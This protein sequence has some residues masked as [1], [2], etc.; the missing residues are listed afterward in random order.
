MFHAPMKIK[1]GKRFETQGENKEG[2][3]SI[4]VKMHWI[5]LK[6]YTLQKNKTMERKK[7]ELSKLNHKEVKRF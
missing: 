1:T 2:N 6:D 3:Y 7:Y 5:G 4:G